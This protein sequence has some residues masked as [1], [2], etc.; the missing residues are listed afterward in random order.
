MD[1]VSICIPTYNNEKTIQQ[2]IESVVSQSYKNMEI[3]I[4]D[5]ASSDQTLSIV[6][7]IH[8]TRIRVIENEKNLGM[9][10]NWNKCIHEASGEYIKLLCA[11][12]ILYADAIRIEVAILRKHKDVTLVE[13][14]T[15]LINDEYKPI[16]AFNRFP[17]FG[18]MDGKRLAKTSLMLNNF[19]GAPCANMFRKKDAMAVGGFDEKFT[20]ILD[21]DLW[22]SL[23][24]IGK[25][26]ILPVALHGFMVRQNSN[27]DQ[28]I[29]SNQDVYVEEHKNLVQKHQ[30]REVLRI[31]DLEVTFSVLCRKLRN[32]MI[33]YYMHYFMRTSK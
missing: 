10:A 23:A 32:Q 14:N 29:N 28:M 11:D 5:D 21:F 31:S 8:D 33:R 1:L 19:F 12:D 9:V 16:G 20:Y 2:T 6:E 15:R 22:V 7:N 24:S 18:K 13:S 27:T 3:L 4:I 25:V 30:E 17:W 26:Y